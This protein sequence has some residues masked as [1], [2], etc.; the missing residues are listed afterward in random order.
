[1]AGGGCGGGGL[2]TKSQNTVNWD[3]LTKFPTTPASYCITDSLSH[4]E[5]NQNRLLPFYEIFNSSFS[6]DTHIIFYPDL[7]TSVIMLKTLTLQLP[8]HEE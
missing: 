7:I 8:I 6:V 4:V 1:M 5:T 3:F 2:V